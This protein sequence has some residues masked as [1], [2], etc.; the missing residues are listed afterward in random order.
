MM[1]YFYEEHSSREERN[2]ML[3]RY[4][5]REVCVSSFPPY[6]MQGTCM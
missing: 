4:S 6:H 2:E 5:K 3:A 1:Y